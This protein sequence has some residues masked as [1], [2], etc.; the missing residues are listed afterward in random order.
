MKSLFCF[1]SPTCV[2]CKTV[3]G[4]LGDFMK[5]NQWCR[6]FLIDTSLSL[7][8]AREYNISSLPAFVL[9]DEDGTVLA[10]MG[11]F[12]QRGSLE[13]MVAPYRGDV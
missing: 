4:W 5:V 8:E 13:K 12:P 2:K 9:L 7:D 10:E 3:E 11:G 1:S 6:F